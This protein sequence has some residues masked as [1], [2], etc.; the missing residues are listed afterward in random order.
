[1]L[2]RRTLLSIIIYR[3]PDQH[4]NNFIDN[5]TNCLDVINNENK[6]ICITGDFNIDL[7]KANEMPYIEGFINSMSSYSCYPM[8]DKP[9]RTTDTTS[10]LIDNIFTNVITHTPVSGVIVTD[11]SDHY[12][13]FSIVH[14]KIQT[15]HKRT[16]QT[17][18]MP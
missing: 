5:I 18:Y 6:N 14:N 17:Q 9:T 4:P 2:N 12:P 7:L 8:I 3:P 10:S 16:L 11:I 13:I 1:M 15:P